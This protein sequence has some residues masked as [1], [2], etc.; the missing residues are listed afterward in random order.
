[1]KYESDEELYPKLFRLL[2]DVMG[3]SHEQ[4]SKILNNLLSRPANHVYSLISPNSESSDT[5]N[6]IITLYVFVP[7]VPTFIG[8]RVKCHKCG[9]V[10][11]MGTVFCNSCL[12]PLDSEN[13]VDTSITI[14][15][16]SSVLVAGIFKDIPLEKASRIAF[17]YSF[18]CIQFPGGLI[19]PKPRKIKMHHAY[20]NGFDIRIDLENNQINIFYRDPMIPQKWITNVVR[21]YRKE[22]ENTFNQFRKKATGQPNTEPK[23]YLKRCKNCGRPFEAHRNDARSCSL[24]ACKKAL[25]RRDKIR[26]YSR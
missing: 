4:A 5:D 17:F 13:K 7:P 24:S 25:S 9:Q 14:P 26:D 6:K 23:K 3:G 8:N 21:D 19:T 20:G 2:K 18:K 10:Y 15:W 22:M 12:I 11:Q 1:M 16:D